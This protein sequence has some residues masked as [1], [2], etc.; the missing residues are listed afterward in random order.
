MRQ[1]PRWNGRPE[2][3]VLI[4]GAGPAG[5]SAALVLGR[6]RRRVVVCDSGRPRNAASHA[7]HGF[8]SRDGMPPKEF[9]RLAR[10]ELRHYETV[11]VIDAEVT[12]AE[13]APESCFNVTI[14]DGRQFVSRKLLLATGVVDNLPDIEGFND[15]YGRS[16]FHCPY[17]DGWELR[18]QPIA[19]YGKGERGCGLSLELTGWSRDLVLCSDG[20]CELDKEARSR[21]ARHRIDV[22]EERVA[23]LEGRDGI[24]SQIVFADGSTLPRRAMFFTT[25]QSQHSSLV[26]RLGCEFNDKGTVRTGRYETTHIRGLFV[27]GDASRAVQWVVVAAAEGAEAAFAIN[28]DLLKEDLD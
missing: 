20:P 4:V 11:S 19:I 17:C 26:L 7:M 2:R 28:T 8:L 5:L 21:L 3:D 18:E 10:E 24:L 25:G 13:C 6:C 22:R 9:L 23:R 16:V 15:F 14:E 27:A 12:A 1:G